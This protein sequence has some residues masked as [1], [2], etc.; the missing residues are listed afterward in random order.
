MPGTTLE[1]WDPAVDT[2]KI[3]VFKELMDQSGVYFW[4]GETLEDLASSQDISRAY[5]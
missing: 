5:Y 1:A 4:L 3:L 2:Q